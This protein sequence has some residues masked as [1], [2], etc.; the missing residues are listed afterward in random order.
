MMPLSISLSLSLS[1]SLFLPRTLFRDGE[2]KCAQTGLLFRFFFIVFFWFFIVSFFFAGASFFLRCCC[3]CCCCGGAGSLG[4]PGVSSII[5]GRD[6]ISDEHTSPTAELECVCVLK[7]EREREAD[8]DERRPAGPL[9]QR[10][11]RPAQ[12]ASIE[13]DP[14]T[15]P[16]RV[17]LACK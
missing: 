12:T 9:R 7:R 10:P 6:P 14:I 16:Y 4:A 15:I 5:G 2:G 17:H 3:C 8:A 1:L 13:V 11:S